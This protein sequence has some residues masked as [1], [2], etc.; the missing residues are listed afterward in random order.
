[1]GLPPFTGTFANYRLNE[2]LDRQTAFTDVIYLIHVRRR[3]TICRLL[4]PSLRPS[5]R[6]YTPSPTLCSTM[7]SFRTRKRT[8]SDCATYISEQIV[9][10]PQ[11]L[12]PST[13]FRWSTKQWP[14]RSPFRLFLPTCLNE[15]HRQVCIV[16]LGLKVG[17]FRSMKH[18]LMRCAMTYRCGARWHR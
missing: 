12:T 11:T 18:V 9:W 8:P 15:S 7:Q 5:M 2:S 13:R 10:V 3:Y 4:L 17:S 6:S 16:G 14:A 1:M